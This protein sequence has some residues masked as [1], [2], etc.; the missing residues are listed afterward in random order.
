[1]T[2]KRNRNRN[3]R[4]Q[5][6]EC[7]GEASP[8]QQALYLTG[9]R[10]ARSIVR[11]IYTIS[12][13]ELN[14]LAHLAVYWTF[15][16]VYCEYCEYYDYYD[17]CKNILQMLDDMKHLLDLPVSTQDWDSIFTPIRMYKMK[18]GDFFEDEIHTIAKELIR[19][20]R[21]SFRIDGGYVESSPGLCEDTCDDKSYDAICKSMQQFCDLGLIPQ[22]T[23]LTILNPLAGTYAGVCLCTLCQYKLS[24]NIEA[25]WSITAID[26]DPIAIA[27]ANCLLALCR[28]IWNKD[29]GVSFTMQSGTFLFSETQKTEVKEV[30]MFHPKKES[31]IQEIHPVNIEVFKRKAS[32]NSHGDPGDPL[33]PFDLIIMASREECFRYPSE[34]LHY[35]E[36]VYQT[37]I[38]EYMQIEAAYAFSAKMKVIVQERSWLTKKHAEQ[39]REWIHQ[40]RP[41]DI[42]LGYQNTI[43]VWRDPQENSDENRRQSTS[44][45]QKGAPSFE[46]SWSDLKPTQGWKLQDPR[47][48]LLIHSI[49]SIGQPLSSYLLGG[50][51]DPE[52][53]YLCAILNS[54]LMRLFME[55]NEENKKNKNVPIVVPDLYNPDEY[56]LEQLIRVLH[57]KKRTLTQKGAS[58]EKIQQVDTLLEQTILDIYQIPMELREF[59]IQHMEWREGEKVTEMR[60]HSVN[61]GR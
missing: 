1:M 36:G 53:D 56:K 33:D 60:F 25:K 40:M 24:E 58:Q 15:V 34:I 57:Q 5:K 41:T 28:S 22:D 12:S 31:Y 47:A 38:F 30:L 3:Q 49:R 26:P 52:D 7:E 10:A 43:C 4:S 39:Y 18:N 46:I 13:Q 48:A 45:H 42:L 14:V 44:I 16:S 35:L 23:P 32:A 55:L 51:P 20:T 59:I 29:P 21:S 19:F 54:H 27:S 61:K 6:I 17:Y 2:Y 9:V 8:L 50:E 11:S 37:R